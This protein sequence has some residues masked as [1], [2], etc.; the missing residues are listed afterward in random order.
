MGE[1]AAAAVRQLCDNTTV[2][3]RQLAFRRVVV[4]RGATA[5]R[6]L[7]ANLPWSH[8]PVGSRP[9]RR[10]GDASASS[11]SVA[12]VVA[13]AS[14]HAPEAAGAAVGG[15]SGDA[16][17]AA[18]LEACVAGVDGQRHPFAARVL[19]PAPAAG[20]TVH[21]VV[22][23]ARARGWQVRPAGSGAAGAWASIEEGGGGRL[24]AV[25]LG[26][27][28][29]LDP[30]FLARCEPVLRD[31]PEVA[32]VAPWM[33]GLPGAALGP[34]PSLPAQ[35]LY[36]QSGGAALWRV[37]AVQEVGGVRAAM[38]PA[39]A[40]WDVAN[41]LLADGWVGVRYPPCSP[42]APRRRPTT[43]P[44]S[45]APG[46][47]RRCS[48][49]S[50]RRWRAT[51]YG[52]RC[53]WSPRPRT[54]RRSMRPEAGAARV[55][56]R[57]PPSWGAG[58]GGAGALG[59]GG[60]GGG[61]RRRGSATRRDGALG[62]AAA[63]EA[64]RPGARAGGGALAERGDPARGRGRAMIGGETGP[65]PVVSVVICTHD[66]ADYLRSALRSLVA[67]AVPRET[68]EVLVVDNRSTDHTPAVAREFADAL[69]AALRARAGDRAVRGAQHG[70]AR[71]ARALRGLLRRRR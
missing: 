46:R 50:R 54:A 9:E 37:A 33:L 1:A 16:V 65:E 17:D 18:L 71:G 28:D 26:A 20:P 6:H 69:P 32:L 25:L 45:D 55:G 61:A 64:G 56:S 38:E 40:A 13:E 14:E 66:R 44:G 29:H 68:F 7:P 53:S 3:E 15:R 4:E 63:A 58:P 41:A 67:Q 24:G 23:R 57:C 5:S 30:D 43:L 36:E 19:V 31:C 42:R 8:H 39:S 70:V 11:G 10:G 48:S 34:C 51:L 35:L 47:A 49:G 12:I 22:E 59:G 62:R 60:A 27:R 52:S 21:G 2:V